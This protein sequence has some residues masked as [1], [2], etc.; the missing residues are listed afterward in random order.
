MKNKATTYILGIAVAVVWGLIIYRIIAAVSDS[1][2]NDAP[3]KTLQIDKGPYND[4]AITPDTT[5]LLLNYRDPFG[6]VK[7]KDT[8]AITVRRNIK[9]ERIPAAKPAIN[10][11]FIQYSGYIL[12][13]ASK[14]LIT[15]ISVNG[16]MATLNEGA[17]FENVKLIRNLRDSIKIS[18]GGV[19]KTINRKSSP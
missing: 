8:A 4:F 16:R 18:Y 7:M 2:D 3:V 5:H 10:W 11:D 17:T 9:K 1:G 6:L 15:L 14:K 19:I 13:P 12:N